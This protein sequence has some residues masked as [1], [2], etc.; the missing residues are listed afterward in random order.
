VDKRQNYSCGK[1]SVTVDKQRSGRLVGYARVSTVEQNL[2]MQTE[3]LLR[4][5]VDKRHLHV[6]KISASSKRRT[7]FDWAIK[8]LRPGDVFVV[9]KL[10]RL[11]RDVRAILKTMD[12]IRDAGASVRSLTEQIDTGSPIGSFTFNLMASLAQLE[13]DQVV[14]RTRAGVDAARR[15]GVKF[16]QPPKLDAKQRAQCKVWKREGL[17]VREIVQ[18]V[19]SEYKITVSH[20]A[21]QN[22]VSKRK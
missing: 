20:G 9:W 16:G 8:S 10:D 7:I 3:A 18:R 2:D 1:T 19:K 15:R 21:V 11:G 22:Y 5:G 12:T 6:E 14:M 13:R 4:A 17:T